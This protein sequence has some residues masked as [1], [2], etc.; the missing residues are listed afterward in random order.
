[1]SRSKL[2]VVGLAAGFSLVLLYLTIRTSGSLDVSP[3]DRAAAE[4]ACQDAVRTTQP[5]ARFPFDADVETQATSRIRLSGSVDVGPEDAP[6][7]RNYECLMVA[8]GTTFT[9]DSVLVWQSH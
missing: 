4:V 6:V 5:D 3:E 1:M 2:V 9:V 7:R 8:E